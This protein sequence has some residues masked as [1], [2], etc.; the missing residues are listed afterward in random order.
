MFAFLQQN[1]KALKD[2]QKE[3]NGKKDFPKVLIRK[4]LFVVYCWVLYL[5][6]YTLKDAELLLEVAIQNE[7]LK[8]DKKVFSSYIMWT[9]TEIGFMLR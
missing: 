5:Y 4:G 6:C 8:K 3:H 2:R 7:S 9:R 1:C